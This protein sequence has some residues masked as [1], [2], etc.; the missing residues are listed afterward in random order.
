MAN[1]YGEVAAYG[2]ETYKQ[3]GIIGAADSRHYAILRLLFP[4]EQL[5]EPEAD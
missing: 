5:L 3:D 4:L 2:E 1:G